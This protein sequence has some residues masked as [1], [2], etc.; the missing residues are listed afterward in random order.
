MHRLGATAVI[1]NDGQML[2]TRRRDL[3][4]W[5]APGGHLDRG[6]TVQ[7]CCVREV[8]EETG[9]DVEIERLVGLYARR[10]GQRGQILWMTF[11]FQCRVAGG[12]LRVT[13]ETTAIGYWPIGKLPINTAY[14]HRRYL[15]DTVNGN[16]T[17]VCRAMP[18]RLWEQLVFQSILRI[19]RWFSRRRS[20]PEFIPARWKLGAFATLFDGDGRVLLVRRR[21]YP[22]W[23]LPGGKVET[24]ETPWEAVVRET[25]EET[26][27]EIEVHRLTGVYSKLSRGE[28]VLN[29][30]GRVVGGQPVPTEEGAESQFFP[31]ASLPD[32]TLPKHIERILDSAA[33]HTDVVFQI[34]DTPSG[35][36]VLGFK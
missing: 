31:V 25:R 6:E 10:Q 35:L 1:L 34:Q 27:L 11:L 3:P 36:K 16:H 24:D 17:A 32:P 7:A 28:L 9:L 4:L 22:V 15:A 13:D 23:N 8:R 14:W 26:G 19:R 12:T 21:D 20:H 2:L 33:R 29:F 30:A 18:T 5:V